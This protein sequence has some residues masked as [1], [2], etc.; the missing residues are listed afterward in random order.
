MKSCLTW[1]GKFFTDVTHMLNSITL[2]INVASLQM[3]HFPTDKIYFQ[4]PSESVFQTQ[5]SLLFV[6]SV[7]SWVPTVLILFHLWHCVL[8]ILHQHQLYCWLFK[9][10]Q[11]LWLVK[12]KLH[13]NYWLSVQRPVTFSSGL[14]YNHD[15]AGLIPHH[16]EQDT[17]P[18]IVFIGWIWAACMVVM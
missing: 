6:C 3:W 14:M 16:L 17:K 15:V 1:F 9:E 5:I 2:P 12:D 8:V 11:P 18:Q 7:W 10:G 4:E 13:Q